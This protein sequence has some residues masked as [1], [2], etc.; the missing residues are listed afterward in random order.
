MTRARR[1]VSD[2][3]D[4]LVVLAA[5]Y[6]AADGH[7]FDEPTVRSGFAPLLT[8][9]RHGAVWVAEVDDGVD[10]AAGALEGY[11]VVTWNWSIEIGGPEAVLDEVYVREQGRGTGSD[12]VRAAERDCR[13]HGMR[14]IFLETERRNDAARRL[15]ERLG[16]RADDSIWMSKILAA[17]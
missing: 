15:Y 16:Y 5:E 7:C 17:E 8:D 2:D 6:C 4:G 1:A 9:D 12:L 3:L 11:V 10:G 13:A 14:R